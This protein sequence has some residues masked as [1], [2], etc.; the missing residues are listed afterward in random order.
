MSF[1]IRDACGAVGRDACRA[2]GAAPGAL[3]A[4]R[5]PPGGHAGLWRDRGLAGHVCRPAVPAAHSHPVTSSANAKCQQVCLLSA[6]PSL[7]SYCI[8]LISSPDRAH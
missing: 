3:G 6:L 5:C 2:R 7:S 4:Q 8:A 1:W